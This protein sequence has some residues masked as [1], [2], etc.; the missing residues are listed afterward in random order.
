[1]DVWLESQIRKLKAMIWDQYCTY[2]KVEEVCSLL[3]FGDC[4]QAS[5]SLSI[6]KERPG[7][8]EHRRGEVRG[9]NGRSGMLVC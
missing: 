6:F 8:S 4:K 9:R 7:G 3:G 5:G 1:M 2:R